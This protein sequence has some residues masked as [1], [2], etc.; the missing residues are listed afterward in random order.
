MKQCEINGEGKPN[1][2]Q[3]ER[4]EKILSEIMRLRDNC[5]AGK[6]TTNSIPSLEP[7]KKRWFI[8]MA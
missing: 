4:L 2:E 6:T 8:K 1:C 5:C 7:L 3:M